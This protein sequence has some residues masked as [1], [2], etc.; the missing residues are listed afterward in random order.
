MDCMA[1]LATGQTDDVVTLILSAIDRSR[2]PVLLAPS[3]NSTMWTQPATQRNLRTLIEDGYRIVG[4]GEG[5][6]ACRQ[7][8]PGR[9]SEPEELLAAL[10]L[11]LGSPRQRRS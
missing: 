5:W 1:K 10:K 8:G 7:I 11:A 3:M 9:M 2:T 4:P 6:Q